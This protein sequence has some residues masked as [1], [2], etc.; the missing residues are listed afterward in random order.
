MPDS[1]EVLKVIEKHFHTRRT[2]TARVLSGPKREA[3]FSAECFVALAQRKILKEGP[4]THWGELSYSKITKRVKAIA[5]S[6]ELSK[7]PDLVAALPTD[8]NS[9]ISLII[10][11]KVISGAENPR[12]TLSDL[13]KQMLNA[14]KIR[15]DA[16]VL[17]IIFIVAATHTK[18]PTYK[19]VLKG[20]ADSVE[21]TFM[22]IKGFRWLYAEKIRR[23][24]DE[25]GTELAYP[26]MHFSLALCAI[27][28]QPSGHVRAPQI[29][30]A[31][32]VMPDNTAPV[33]RSLRTRPL[34]PK[35]KRSPTRIPSA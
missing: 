11:N 24:F 20:V 30:V 8:G 3:W 13:K 21:D 22:R 5:G 16:E 29:P 12:K 15:P 2:H 32:P 27:E 14:R 4:I 26:A 9:A 35:P 34:I 17:G 33:L 28:L 19:G 7:L 31:S 25:V 6:G 10:E 1:T 23:V 18:K